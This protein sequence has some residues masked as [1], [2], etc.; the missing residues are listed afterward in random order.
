MFAKKIGYCANETSY[1]ALLEI[2]K[3]KG[4]APIKFVLYRYIMGGIFESIEFAGNEREV[5]RKAFPF[6]P[7]IYKPIEEEMEGLQW[8]M[9]EGRL[10]RTR[11]NPW[12]A[13]TDWL[14]DIAMG[15]AY[16]QYPKGIWVKVG[17]PNTWRQRRARR[18]K[19]SH[20]RF[21]ELGHIL[22]KRKFEMK[23]IEDGLTFPLFEDRRKNIEEEIQSEI[24]G[25]QKNIK[26]ILAEMKFVRD[27]KTI[28]PRHFIPQHSLGTHS[29]LN[30]N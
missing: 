8:L 7:V 1:V 16:N 29:N 27:Q 12:E 17:K 28:R 4:G 21:G 23:Q 11:I 9:R 13:T 22:M 10:L 18:K 2:S 30:N 26:R 24:E 3:K 19:R 25:A 6:G 14:E 5:A 20:L 15:G